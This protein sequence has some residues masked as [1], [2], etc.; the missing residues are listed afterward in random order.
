MSDLHWQKSTFSGGGG[1]GECIELAAGDDTTTVHLRESDNPTV[2]LPLSR[3]TLRA[4]IRYAR[5]TT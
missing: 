4:L 3:R 2:T 5:A 1:N